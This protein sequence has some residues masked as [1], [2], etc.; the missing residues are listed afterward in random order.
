LK[1][2]KGLSLVEEYENLQKNFKNLKS[3]R[4][5]IKFNS[6][7]AKLHCHYINNNVKDVLDFLLCVFNA[8]KFIEDIEL[9]DK[10]YQLRIHMKNDLGNNQV[11]VR[12]FKID[13]DTS[14]IDF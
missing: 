14:V 8:D 11:A 2:L 12:I 1:L 3:K 13:E 10:T 7:G 4:E 5:V 6:M 9:D